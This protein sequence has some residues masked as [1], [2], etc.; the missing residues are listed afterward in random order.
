MKL[1]VVSVV[2]VV[3]VAGCQG[4]NVQEVQ[5][6]EAAPVNCATAEGDLR[7]LQSEKASTAKMIEDGVTAVTPVGLVVG[8]ATGKE[9]GK[10]QVATGDYNKMI[11]Q[12]V[13]QIKTTCG[14]K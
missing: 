3:L 6:Q 9:K 14:I 10:M 8:T 7:T 2:L 13:A 4:P 11:D 12:K 5:K 1:N